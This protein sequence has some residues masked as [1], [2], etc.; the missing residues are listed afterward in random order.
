[1]ILH[2]TGM[3][4]LCYSKSRGQ[5]FIPKTNLA[6]QSSPARLSLSLASLV[7]AQQLSVSLTK[8]FPTLSPV[9]Q[10]NEIHKQ[11]CTEP[12]T[13]DITGKHSQP[14]L[15]SP[16]KDTQVHQCVCHA[17]VFCCLPEHCMLH[18]MYSLLHG[19]IQHNCLLRHGPRSG[20]FGLMENCR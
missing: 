2:T 13:Q 16:T 1:M 5:F 8:R 20:Q 4:V 3:N 11:S 12:S 15:V 18:P 14:L 7:F 6:R 10:T 19:I 17:Q 9:I